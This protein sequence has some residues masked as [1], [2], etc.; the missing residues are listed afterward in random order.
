MEENILD[1]LGLQLVDYFINFQDYQPFNIPAK[2]RDD[3]KGKVYLV[4]KKSKNYQVIKIIK[5]N[6]YDANEIKS[7]DDQVIDVLKKDLNIADSDFKLLILV[8]NN[9]QQNEFRQSPTVDIIVATPNQMVN[10]LAKIYPSITKAIKIENIEQ[11]QDTEKEDEEDTEE[12]TDRQKNWKKVN[13][14]NRRFL[15]DALLKS[16]NPHLIVT[17]LFFALP[18]VAYV[19]FSILINSNPDIFKGGINISIIN[20]VFGASN[21]NL[22]YGANQ[23]WRWLVYPLVQFD[24]LSLLFSLWMFYRVGRYIEGFYGLW[25]SVIIWI[26]AVILT[27]VVQTTVDHI[28]MLNGFEVLTLISIGAMFPI[29]WNYKIFKSKVTSKI[30]VTFI[31]M[32]LFWMF[33]SSMN[34]VTLLYWMIAIGSG[35]LLGAVVSYHNRKL[36]VF[37]A[38]SPVAI[39]LLVLFAILVAV[40]NPYYHFDNNNWTKDTLDIYKQFNIV[41]QGFIDWVMSHYFGR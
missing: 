7:K 30:V 14:Q 11:Y 3:A 31:L 6:I 12:L 41:N 33:F 26:V 39:G 37:Y 36:T 29:I 38:F 19:I 2:F 13:F 22:V 17:W 21:R 32:L 18:I 35:W 4:N 20:L 27:G 25:K 15:K 28:K 23:Y 8:L 1:V 5:Q 40:L 10:E 9:D 24:T 16:T 34:S